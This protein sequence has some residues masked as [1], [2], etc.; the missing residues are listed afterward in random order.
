[1]CS[2][3]YSEVASPETG[4]KVAQFGQARPVSLDPPLG[5][6]RDD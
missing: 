1:L 6:R 3:P 5:C 4:I 2:R